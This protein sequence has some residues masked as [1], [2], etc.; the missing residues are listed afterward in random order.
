MGIWD[1]TT[2][3]LM[4]ITEFADGESAKL[5]RPAVARIQE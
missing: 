3:E 4:D 1:K 5:P 2:D